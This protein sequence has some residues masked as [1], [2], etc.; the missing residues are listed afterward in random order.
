MPLETSLPDT[1]EIYANTDPV[2]EHLI[3]IRTRF[4]DRGDIEGIVEE[5]RWYKS[6]RDNAES[7]GDEDQIVWKQL[8]RTYGNLSDDQIEDLVHKLDE[9]E[10]GDYIN[11]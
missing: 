3:E 1:P 4:V 10:N 8:H 11:Q 9:S 7:I 2:T 5:L 6:L